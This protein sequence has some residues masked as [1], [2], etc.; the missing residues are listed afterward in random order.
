MRP[1]GVFLFLGESGVGKTELAKALSRSL[2]SSEKSIIR[3]D[4]SEFI[5]KHAVA[6]LIG[7]PPGYVGYEEG[8]T[9]T[10]KIRRH[11]YSVVLFDEIEKAHPDV[12]NLLL[13][14]TDDGTL[15]D[16]FGRSV[17]FRHSVIILTSNIGADKF[18]NKNGVGFLEDG[19]RPNLQEK[20]KEYFRPEFINRLDEII[21]FSSL[22]KETLK[23]IARNRANKLSARMKDM[24]FSLHI[25]DAALTHLAKKSQRSGMGAR[26]LARIFTE[27]IENPISRSIVLDGIKSETTI[28]VDK[29]PQKDE[30]IFYY[31]PTSEKKLSEKSA[32]TEKL[33]AISES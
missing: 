6:K 24:G 16:S 11:P 20:L 1:V 3:Y 19:E 23:T 21:L 29:D 13:Q 17:S 25:T 8:G 30:L 5:E 26:P 10:E 27:E 18:K 7:A 4:M 32:D 15:T 31:T 22:D 33:H 9:L 2:F 28:S 12:L 14:I